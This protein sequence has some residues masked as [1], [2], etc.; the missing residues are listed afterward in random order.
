M[1]LREWTFIDLA[2]IVV[3]HKENFIDA[4]S[5]EALASS[6]LSDRFKGFLIEEDGEII[7][8]V[9]YD[10]GIDEADVLNLVVKK[11]ER[12]K[13]LATSLL[14]RVFEEVKKIELKR[15]FLEVRESNLPAINTYKKVGF[16]EIAKRKN[17][18]QDKETAIIMKKEF[19]YN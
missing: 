2:K 15:L 18:Y 5:Y 8:T 6:F 11:S 17:Y 16:I 3:F 9:S 12:K 4:W 1:T 13:G 7:A 19:S 10:L 14:E